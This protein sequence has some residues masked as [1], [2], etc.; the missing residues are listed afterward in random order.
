MSDK[1]PAR[2]R[3]SP[4]EAG[5]AAGRHM[6]AAFR[7]VVPPCPAPPGDALA[8]Q[9][10][11]RQAN[12]HDGAV[13]A[14][15]AELAE[16]V[17]ATTARIRRETAVQL[18]AAFVAGRKLMPEACVLWHDAQVPDPQPALYCRAA[19]AL[20]D[21][22]L[23]ELERPAQDPG[24]RLSG[25]G[26]GSGVE[27]VEDPEWVNLAEEQARVDHARRQAHAEQGGAS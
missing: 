10:R 24:Q 6:H 16:R 7:P 17:A 12:D 25:H 19:V 26:E 13:E 22:L 3:G 14:A 27:H 15:C 5:P 9:I 23:A 11:A 8:E 4:A 2:E 18:L 1:D 20:A 21:R